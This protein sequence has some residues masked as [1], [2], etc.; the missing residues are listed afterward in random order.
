MNVSAFEE[1]RYTKEYMHKHGI[2]KVR[3]GTY[4]S[5]KLTSE[6]IQSLQKEIYGATDCCF[7]CGSKG[8]FAQKCDAY[9]EDDEEEEE[10][11][12]EEDE[13]L[14]GCEYCDRTF[15]TA[16]GC[17]IHERS[18]KEKNTRRVTPTKRGTCYRCGREG[19]YSPDCYA[20]TDSKGYTLDSDSDD[21]DD[22]D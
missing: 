8:H 3:G 6:Q 7:K 20:K 9:Y 18:C 10:E 16:F 1:D 19:H 21:D 22:E 12:E 17:G 14:W 13:E 5:M 11:E 2:D 4:C 15:T